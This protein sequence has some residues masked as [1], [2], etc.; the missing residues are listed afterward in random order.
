MVSQSIGVTD[1]FYE[2]LKNDHRT[3]D[4][5]VDIT[6]NQ[7]IATMTGTVKSNAT[8]KAV[9]EIIKRQPEV[10]TV[11]NEMKIKQ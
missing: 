11:I 3:K 5:V 7:G 1:R 9:E 2:A 6:F 10:M 8:W 4:A